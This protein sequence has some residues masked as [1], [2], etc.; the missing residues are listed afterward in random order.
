MT[1][2]YQRTNL[3]L[4]TCIFSFKLS[5]TDIE[6]VKQKALPTNANI[7]KPR[8]ITF[9]SGWIETVNSLNQFIFISDNKSDSVHLAIDEQNGIVYG[10]RN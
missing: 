9:P 7:E 5:K 3:D 6:A 2:I 1:D 10:W 8:R 4:N